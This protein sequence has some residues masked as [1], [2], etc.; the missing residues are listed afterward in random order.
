MRPL[1]RAIPKEMLPV[2][3]KPAIQHVVDEATAAGIEEILVV[4]APEKGGRLGYIGD[5]TRCPI[6]SAF[7]WPF[8]PR[9]GAQGTRSRSTVLNDGALTVPYRDNIVLPGPL[10]IG[11]LIDFQRGVETV[12]P[13]RIFSSASARAKGFREDDGLN[14]CRT[15]VNAHVR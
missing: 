3:T 2:G 7:T 11:V 9:L 5:E 10:A 8:S 12:E 1:T 6:G 14:C 15:V 13:C 4:I